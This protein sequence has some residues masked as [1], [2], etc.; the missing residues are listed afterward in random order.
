MFLKINDKSKAAIASNLSAEIYDLEIIEK[1]IQDN[2]ENFT[3]FLL[4]GKDIIQPEND[5]KSFITS[6][7]LN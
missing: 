2:K 7:Y 6:F 3:R 5:D 1:D 4:M